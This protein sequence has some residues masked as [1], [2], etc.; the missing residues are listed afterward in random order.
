M[1]P[2]VVTSQWSLNNR[3]GARLPLTSTIPLTLDHIDY[4]DKEEV[5]IVC[6]GQL[7]VTHSDD[8]GYHDIEEGSGRFE[9]ISEH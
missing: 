2:D 6:H 8:S 4:F 9:S 5:Y 1:T 3:R 7:S